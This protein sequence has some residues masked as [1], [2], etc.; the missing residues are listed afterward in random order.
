MQPFTIACS[1]LHYLGGGGGEQWENSPEKMND[2]IK[3]TYFHANSQYGPFPMIAS[4]L[5]KEQ[6]CSTCKHHTYLPGLIYNSIQV[7]LIPI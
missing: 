1:L 5:S 4:C 6:F 2:L 7:K 3:I